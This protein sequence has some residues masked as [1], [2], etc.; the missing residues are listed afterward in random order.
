MIHDKD[1]FY[2]SQK[3]KDKRAHILRR[4]K[5]TDQL[6]LRAGR[7]IPATMVHHILPRDKYPE[8]S[9]QDWNLISISDATHRELHTLYGELTDAGKELMLRTA[10]EH[11]IKLSKLT[12]VI[13]L[14]GTGKT[15]AVKSVLKDGL[16]YDLDYIAAAFQ[17][18]KPG[19]ATQ[20]AR[21][22]ANSMVKAFA[23]NARKYTS[24]VYII[25]TAPS[26]QELEAIDPDEIVICEKNYERKKIDDINESKRII[27][28]IKAYAE[29]NLIPVKVIG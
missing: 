16:C 13:G 5:Y 10:H 2:G 17:L 12:L 27:A 22:M 9:L 25:R 26:L 23:V 8:Y 24:R 19:E 11:G 7:R 28:E 3:W 20:A 29:A 21:K 6:E 14:P 18:R 1:P 4:D 15:T